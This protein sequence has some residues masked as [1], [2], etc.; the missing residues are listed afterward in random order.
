[1]PSASTSN[2]EELLPTPLFG[3]ENLGSS[4]FNNRY[5]QAEN[6]KLSALERHVK[7]S[8]ITPQPVN[9]AAAKRNICHNFRKGRC[10]FGKK[11][12][13]SHGNESVITTN[14][15]AAVPNNMLANFSMSGS[16]EELSDSVILENRQ[17]FNEDDDSYMAEAKKRKRAG[18]SETLIPP[19][20]SLSALKQQRKQDSPWTLQS[21]R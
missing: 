8:E 18:I 10:Q 3:R 15:T 5:Q 7:L 14:N 12:K 21:K 13:Y 1:M 2:S 11:C 20:K 6:I 19:K 9:N 4:V 17:N 16:H